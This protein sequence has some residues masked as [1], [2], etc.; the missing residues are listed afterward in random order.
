MQHN[1]ALVSPS[2]REELAPLGPA[3][4][5]AAGPVAQRII[6]QIQYAIPEYQRPLRGVFGEAV[7]DGVEQGI[8][9]FL[10]RLLDNAPASESTREVFRQL[11]RLEASER[12]GLEVLHSSLRIGV[13]VAWKRLSE[14]GLAAGVQ[15][16]TMV[17]LAGVL[18]AYID[19][20]S[21]LSHEGYTAAQA[22]AAGALERRRK[23]LLEV[24]VQEAAVADD[25]LEELARTAEWAL[26]DRLAV[27]VVERPDDPTVM[28]DPP[29]LPDDVLVNLE[30]DVP[31]V[32]IPHRGD[33]L[34]PV[35]L[36]GWRAVQGPVVPVAE[37]AHSLRWARRLVE[38]RDAGVVEVDTAPADDT[39]VDGQVD[40]Q[41]GEQVD[42]PLVGDEHLLTLWLLSDPPLARLLGERALAP[43]S[44]VNRRQR[45][46]LAET[47]LEW[48]RRRGSAPDIAAQLAVHPQTVRY[49]VHQLEELYGDRMYDPDGRVWLAA[50]LLAQDLLRRA[51]ASGV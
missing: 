4:R 41:A 30:G 44:G 15:V 39:A 47:L 12:R 45:E 49:R 11:G 38:L 2:A 46:R 3:L 34:V 36:R 16:E 26:P 20:L 43:L 51:T 10:D 22:R 33:A 7:R 1:A 14:I 42:L 29:D 25:I 31:C 35:D 21:E 28:P 18:F 9:E 6:E 37:A 23:R 8:F 27:A 32:V 5:E 48:I 40:G 17:E 24:L 50:G 19:E 13:R